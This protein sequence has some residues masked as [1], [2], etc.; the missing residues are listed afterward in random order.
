LLIQA[1]PRFQNVS[2]LDGPHKQ[3]PNLSMTQVHFT[4]K[5]AQVLQF[6]EQNPAVRHS[7]AALEESHFEEAY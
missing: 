6:L 7:P 1:N 5:E 2:K 4:T 3:E